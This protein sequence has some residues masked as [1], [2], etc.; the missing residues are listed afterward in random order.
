MKILLIEDDELLGSGLQQGLSQA[1]FVVEWVQRGDQAEGALR[2]GAYDCLV[3]DWQLPGRSGL[4]V[5]QGLRSRGQQTPVLMLTARDALEDR[6]QGLDTGADDYLVKPVAL[7]ELAARLRALIRR[8]AGQGSPVFTWGALTLDPARHECHLGG[9]PVSLSA[10]EFS[11]LAR[12]ISQPRRPVSAEQL[13]Q[14]L[15]SWDQDI[16][17]NA[18]EVYIHHLR[19]KLGGDWIKTIRGVGYV[20]SPDKA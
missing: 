8:A 15:Y 4:Q 5:L 7:E 11:V 10:R 12:L 14:A 19:K 16:A 1:G 13:A 18:V 6:I 2:A 3:L 17:S 20:L 9:A